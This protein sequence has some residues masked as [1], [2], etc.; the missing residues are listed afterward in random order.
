M[1]HTGWSTVVISILKSRKRRQKKKRDRKMLCE[2][3]IPPIVASE[4]EERMREITVQDMKVFPQR[5]SKASLGKE[6]N[7]IITP[8]FQTNETYVGYL[9]CRIAT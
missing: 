7:V 4:D 1:Y 5:I 3:A 2:R 6:N 8:W 9:M